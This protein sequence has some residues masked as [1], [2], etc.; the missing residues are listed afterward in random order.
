MDEPNGIANVGILIGAKEYQGKG[1]GFEA[2]KR[3]CDYLFIVWDI[4]K[5]EA[6]CM[7]ANHAMINICQ[8][9]GMVEEGR[10]SDHFILDGK[11]TDL[12]HWGKFNEKSI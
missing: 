12:I 11:T 7:A 2:W 9:Y 6:G 3:I 1:Y 4:R 8:K 5:I 10:Q